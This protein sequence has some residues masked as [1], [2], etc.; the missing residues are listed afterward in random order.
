MMQ[1]GDEYFRDNDEDPEEEEDTDLEE[2]LEYRN[3]FDDMDIPE[4]AFDMEEDWDEDDV[5]HI[6][7]DRVHSAGGASQDQER[8]DIQRPEEA[9]GGAHPTPNEHKSSD[10]TTRVEL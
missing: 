9:P 3:L 4:F 1:V 7:A 6:M 2:E 10:H 5:S 8:G